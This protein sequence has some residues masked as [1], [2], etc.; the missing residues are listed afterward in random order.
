MEYVRGHP[1]KQLRPYNFFLRVGER[2]GETRNMKFRHLV[3]I[4]YYGIGKSPKKRV[5]ANFDQNNYMEAKINLA[6]HVGNFSI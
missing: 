1:K 4:L 6:Y 2:G 5:F 3:G